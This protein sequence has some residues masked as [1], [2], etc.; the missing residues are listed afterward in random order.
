MTQG[1]KLQRELTLTARTAYARFLRAQQFS[2][3]FFLPRREITLSSPLV[4]VESD[5]LDIPERESQRILSAL[6]RALIISDHKERIG[7]RFR[8][9]SRDYTR[10]TGLE[11]SWAHGRNINERA[12]EKLP[13]GFNESLASQR[14]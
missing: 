2:I 4:V 1:D 7:R 3:G 5:V 14:C 11:S 8:R 13:F 10:R 6:S 12:S 9:S